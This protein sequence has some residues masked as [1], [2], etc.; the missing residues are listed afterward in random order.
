MT[1]KALHPNTRLSQPIRVRPPGQGSWAGAMRF[2]RELPLLAVSVGLGVVALCLHWRGTTRP[3][4]LA[5][6]GG[7]RPCTRG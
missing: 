3:E 2:P 5:R 6:E 4:S 7:I 1:T